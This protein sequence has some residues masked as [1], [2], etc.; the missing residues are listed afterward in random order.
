[1]FAAIASVVVVAFLADRA[2]LWLG[3]LCLRWHEAA[4]GEGA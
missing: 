2:L 3:A 1:M 4:A